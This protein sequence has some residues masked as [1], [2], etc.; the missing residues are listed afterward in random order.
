MLEGLRTTIDI[1]LI[2]ISEM[3]STGTEVVQALLADE[4]DRWM[5]LAIIICFAICVAGGWYLVQIRKRLELHRMVSDRLLSSTSSRDLT[6]LLFKVLFASCPVGAASLYL[7]PLAGD[8]RLVLRAKRGPATDSPDWDS[9]LSARELP[10]S[11]SFLQHAGA[12]HLWGLRIG[13]E[14]LVQISLSGTK[15]HHPTKR[16]AAFLVALLA[17][18]V[19]QL[20]ARDEVVAMAGDSAGAS[21]AS[22]SS[23]L[24]VS[25]IISSQQLAVL[26][27]DIMLRSLGDAV[28]CIL[29]RT[30]SSHQSQLEPVAARGLDS[31]V[32]K[33]ILDATEGKAGPLVVDRST[34]EEDVKAVFAKAGLQSLLAMPLM[35]SG[36]EVGL[37]LLARRD[38][39][40][41]QQ[42]IRMAE[43]NATRLEL[44][45]KNQRYHRAVFH[46]YKDTLRAIIHTLESAS[47]V[48][49]GHT[50][51]VV[52]MATELAIHV[53]LTEREVSG[54]RL[55]AELHDVGM[56]G[57]P[58]DLTVS[59]GR[60][61]SPEFDLVK[62]HPGIGAVLTAPIQHPTPIAPL[63]L[64]HHERFDGYGYPEGLSGE[65]IPLGA[66]IIGLAEVFDAM[67]TP[68]S[69]RKALSFEVAISR[70]KDLAGTQL[71]PV[72][73][74]AFV[75]LADNKWWEAIRQDSL[76]QSKST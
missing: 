39:H 18:I 20:R 8:D 60:I 28:G 7:V 11:Q 56:V 2:Q 63:I 43:V 22:A 33:T 76:Q 21:A 12:L 36:Q 55:A 70:L 34:S 6:D 9:E 75:E 26:L 69:Y 13:G 45:I 38:G 27:L 59:A 19:S 15:D 48:L 40:F 23:S 62:Q 37:I 50:G 32:Q 41:G 17:P 54:I 31:E 44:T 25:T 1:A 73:V 51:R 74:A 72:L 35:G 47:K 65:D 24:L 68:R 57:L 67:L 46:N 71:D 30:G 4:Q 3:V 66:R 14:G 64:H 42:Q 49:V 16:H 5:G 52:S 61:S 29:F 53:G 10:N 58:D